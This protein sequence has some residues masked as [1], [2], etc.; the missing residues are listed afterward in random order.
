[1]TDATHNTSQNLPEDVAALRALVLTAMAECDALRAE[2]DVAVSE[3]DILLT[4][5]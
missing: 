2:R 3:R 1:M 4:Q 5:E